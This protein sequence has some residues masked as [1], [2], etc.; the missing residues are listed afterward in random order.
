MD[1]LH[2]VVRLSLYFLV[3]LFLG[4]VSV[5]SYAE[6]IAAT[7]YAPN[8]YTIP[9]N[10]HFNLT[11]AAGTWTTFST[12]CATGY[13]AGGW[14]S[15]DAG[16]VDNGTQA[17]STV[18]AQGWGKTTGACGW[19]FSVTTMFTCPTNYTK[20]SGTPPTCRNNVTVYTCPTG[21]NWTLEGQSC[22]RPDCVAPEV[23]DPE[24]GICTAPPCLAKGTTYSSGYYLM[25]T[26]PAAPFNAVTCTGSC[27]VSFS[28]Y[29]PGGVSLVDGISTYYAQGEWQYLGPNETCSGATTPSASTAPPPPTCGPNQYYGTINDKEVCVDAT[30]GQPASTTP[31][32]TPGPS[33]TSDTTT[34]PDGSTTKTE[35]TTNPDRSSTTTTTTTSG[36]GTST[37][38]TTSTEAA[39]GTDPQK[40]LCEAN[41]NLPEC[42]ASQ[43]FCAEN[44]DSPICKTSSFGGACGA[45]TCDGDAIQCAIARD[46]HQRN[47][48]MFDTATSLSTLGEQAAAGTDPQAS[49]YPTAPGQQ[50][51]I[52]LASSIDTT[53]P[54]ASGCLQDKSF[55]IMTS[56]LVIPFSNICPY[57]E[58]MGNIVLAFALLA[59]ARIAFSG[60]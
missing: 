9:A 56:T 26:S 19:R 53:N 5:L 43:G 12:A 34:S 60:V 42:K 16:C 46:Q 37:T 45:F 47:C 40:S 6:T 3:G 21:Q 13:A 33:T 54:F 32:P 57:L 4:G 50:Q 20:Q 41:P 55:T 31:A 11:N 27:L 18:A 7:A 39:P 36:D 35:T 29:V 15:C 28:G 1:N 2:R 14:T 30:T 24:T 8:T 25:G 10:R 44:P 58:A 22:T 49:S 38:T 51:T 17:D 48:T 59:A 23:R 52:N